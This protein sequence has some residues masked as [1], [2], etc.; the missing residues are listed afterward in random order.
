MGRTAKKIDELIEKRD[1][2]LSEVNKIEE[3]IMRL[4]AIESQRIAVNSPSVTT[5]EQNDNL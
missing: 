3:R 5:E 2:L 1:K 4:Q